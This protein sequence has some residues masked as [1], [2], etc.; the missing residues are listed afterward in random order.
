MTT[1]TVPDMTCGHC[2]GTITKAIKDADGA[3]K[4]EI[5]L[6]RHTVQVESKLAETELAGVISEAG[7]TPVRAA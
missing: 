4:V 7:Y 3:A 6:D 1:F 2:V 5:S